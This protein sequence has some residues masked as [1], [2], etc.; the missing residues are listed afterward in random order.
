VGL[1]DVRR[2]SCWSES[3]EALLSSHPG[4][5]ERQLEDIAFRFSLDRGDQR[6]LE[7]VEVWQVCTHLR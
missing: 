4:G 3:S 5:C 2:L 6:D 7:F 1:V